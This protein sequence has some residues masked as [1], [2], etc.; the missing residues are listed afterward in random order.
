MKK[1]LF[2]LILFSNT[3]YAK[4]EKINYLDNLT[5]ENYNINFNK[6]IYEY[7]INIDNEDHLNIDYELSDDSKYVS[8]VGNGNF[9]KSD[10][11]I[12]IN[13]NND[14]F[15]KIHVHKTIPVSYVKNEEVKEMA[16][17][18]KEMILFLIIII[19]SSL[20]VGFYYIT[21]INNKTINI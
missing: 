14:Y 2:I 5:I 7:D 19:S 6:D 12:I 8:V 21:F 18:K 13:V 17:N 10:N 20:I 3:I 1:I 4:E 11:L 15:Y 9:N 16:S